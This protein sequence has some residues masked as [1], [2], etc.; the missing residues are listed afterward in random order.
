MIIKWEKEWFV[1]RDAPD[2]KTITF[3]VYLIRKEESGQIVFNSPKNISFSN[4]NHL[5]K[6]FK[7]ELLFLLVLRQY[8]VAVFL[9]WFDPVPIKIDKRAKTKAKLQY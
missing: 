4:E 1:C 3:M 8:S 7:N 2:L 6:F 5:F 9:L